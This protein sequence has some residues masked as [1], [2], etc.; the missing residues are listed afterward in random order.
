VSIFP[1]ELSERQIEVLARS[2]LE[3]QD[4]V[5]ERLDQETQERFIEEAMTLV[6]IARR[7]ERAN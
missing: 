5:W 2:L 4:D 1:E 7:L 3:L 6:A